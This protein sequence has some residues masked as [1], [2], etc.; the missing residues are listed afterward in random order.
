MALADRVR[1][2]APA[3]PATLRHATAGARSDAPDCARL[4]SDP[5]QSV[6]VSHCRSVAER[7]AEASTLLAETFGRIA[8]WWIGGAALPAALLEADIDRAILA[9]DL[10]AARAALAI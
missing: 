8:G 1:R 5:C 4:R 10:D 9:G 7:R 3:T 2:Y 6:A